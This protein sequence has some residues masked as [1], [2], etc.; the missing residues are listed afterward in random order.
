MAEYALAHL[1]DPEAVAPATGVG[2][3]APEVVE[4]PGKLSHKSDVYSFGVLLLEL[5]TGRV[6]MGSV[7]FEE[8]VDLPRWARCVVKEEWTSELLDVELLRH[9]DA[10]EEIG[11]TLQLAMDCTAALP[12]ERPFMEEIMARVSVLSGEGCA[13]LAR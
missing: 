11:Y 8:G 1:F 12:N 5:L 9:P 4:D 6:P 2:Y 3:R 13:Y 10:E 7:L